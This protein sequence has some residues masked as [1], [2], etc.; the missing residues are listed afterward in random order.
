[1]TAP[2]ARPRHAAARSERIRWYA[3]LALETAVLAFV[4]AAVLI[5]MSLAS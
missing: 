2:H 1:M 4:F 3:H 5:A